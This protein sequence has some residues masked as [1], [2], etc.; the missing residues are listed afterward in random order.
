MESIKKRDLFLEDFIEIYK[1]DPCSWKV[2]LKECGDKNKKLLTYEKLAEKLRE[3]D[4]ATNK[5]SIVKKINNLESLFRKEMKKLKL[6]YTQEQEKLKYI[7]P[8][9]GTTILISSSPP[10]LK[11]LIVWGSIKYVSSAIH[12]YVGWNFNSGNYLFT[13]DPK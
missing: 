3:K 2:K 1:A 13:T 7:S 11:G 9:Y 12:K 6:L 4:P 8:I 10:P 5:E